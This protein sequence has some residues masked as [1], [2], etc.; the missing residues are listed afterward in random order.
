MFSPHTGGPG[1]VMKTSAPERQHDNRLF[2]FVP[3]GH[4]VGRWIVH[5]RSQ[6]FSLGAQHI[7]DV[8]FC[9]DPECARR[10][11]TLHAGSLGHRCTGPYSNAGLVGIDYTATGCD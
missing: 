5:L 8:F 6:V 1:P 7:D 11:A 3:V 4:Q 9:F 2:G 10:S